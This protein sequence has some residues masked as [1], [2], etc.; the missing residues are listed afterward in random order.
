[1][2]AAIDHFEAQRFVRPLRNF[3]VDPGVRRHLDAAVAARPILRGG[4]QARA[5]A[6]AAVVSGDVPAF[7]I[8][9]GT[10]RIAA[11]SVRAEVDLGEATFTSPV[12]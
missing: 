8:A 12:M 11:I 5:D 1:M 6:L 3:V 7:Q 10:L 2:Y 9:Y 4:E